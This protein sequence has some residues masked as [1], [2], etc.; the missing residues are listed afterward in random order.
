MMV[1]SVALILNCLVTAYIFYFFLLVILFCPFC[2]CHCKNIILPSKVTFLST[3]TL[4]FHHEAEENC[5]EIFCF[6]KYFIYT[7]M[8]AM[9][10]NKPWNVAYDSPH[11]KSI[12]PTKLPLQFCEFLAYGCQFLEC[13]FWK[14]LFIYTDPIK[15]EGRESEGMI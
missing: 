6:S 2:F 12:C 5:G 3:C 9:Y 10:Y 15:S 8:R 7:L 13:R 1:L 4:K 14:C 11:G